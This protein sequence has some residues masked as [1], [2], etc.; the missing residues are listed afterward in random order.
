MGVYPSGRR[1]CR[2]NRKGEKK[3]KRN[4]ISR[5]EIGEK[6]RQTLGR[7]LEG[8]VQ[9]KGMWKSHDLLEKGVGKRSSL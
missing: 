8:G 4:L 2:L 6:G 1:S 3:G 9:R 5:K 7:T